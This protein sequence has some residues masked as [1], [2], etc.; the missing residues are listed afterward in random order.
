MK[1]QNNNKAVV[2]QMQ[3]TALGWKSCQGGLEGASG[4][5]TPNL[6]SESGKGV[7]CL[8]Q[9]M[10]P[11]HNSN[12]AHKKCP[13]Q[14]LFAGTKMNHPWMGSVL[15]RAFYQS[16]VM[17]HPQVEF[18]PSSAWVPHVGSAIKG[19]QLFQQQLSIAC[20][21]PSFCKATKPGGC[22]AG[23]VK[24]PLRAAFV[25]PYVDQ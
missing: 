14:H 21:V 13:N 17:Q 8:P 11:L 3:K 23:S 18:I 15:H 20:L 4:I 10:S 5:R 16:S 19:V 7:A 22:R 24:V 1:S 12:R 6:Y 25:A 9:K 2:S